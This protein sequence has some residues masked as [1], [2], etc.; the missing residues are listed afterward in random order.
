MAV[1]RS[2]IRQVEVGGERGRCGG[3]GRGARM[4][5]KKGEEDGIVYGD[6]QREAEGVPKV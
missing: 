4:I 3:E 2:Q 6:A 5:G 1:R